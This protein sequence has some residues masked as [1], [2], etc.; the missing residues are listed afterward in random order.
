MHSLV[1]KRIM[2]KV[3]QGLIMS[4]INVA[5]SV[6]QSNTRKTVPS[7]TK[8]NVNVFIS[9][10]KV[11]ALNVDRICCPMILSYLRILVEINIANILPN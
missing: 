2:I 9:R 10:Q 3:S 7:S 5:S 11:F 4:R 8:N 1:I 6:V